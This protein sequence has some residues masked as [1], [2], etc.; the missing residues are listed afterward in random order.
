[1]PQHLP[2]PVVTGVPN[3][4]AITFNAHL[5]GADEVKL[6]TKGPTD[7]ILP[8]AGRLDATFQ[9]SNVV[10]GSGVALTTGVAKTVTSIN[11]APGTWDVFGMA[12]CV[13]V[14]GTTVTRFEG[15]ASDTNDTLVDV[16][17]AEF[18]SGSFTL[19]AN[20]LRLA[21]PVAQ[22]VVA[23]PTVVYLVVLAEF[24]AATMKGFGRISARRAL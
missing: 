18:R 9:E 5:A 23:S 21:I 10:P 12:G 24:A 11:L 15:S 14:A 4:G 7:I 6:R 8:T 17:A 1:V 3:D 19:G 13:G 22:Y 20:S 16:N 2:P